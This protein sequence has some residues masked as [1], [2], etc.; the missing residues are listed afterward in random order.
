MR[1]VVLRFVAGRHHFLW[2]LRERQWLRAT[3]LGRLLHVANLL[4]VVKLEVSIVDWRRNSSIAGQCNVLIGRAHFRHPVVHFNISLAGMTKRV[5]EQKRL[6]SRAVF[7][8]LDAHRYRRNMTAV[9]QFVADVTALGPPIGIVAQQFAR[10]GDNLLRVLIEH[11]SFAVHPFAE[12]IRCRRRHIEAVDNH[13]TTR[14]WSI[15]RKHHVKHLR[16]CVIVQRSIGL[17]CNPRRNDFVG[18]DDLWHL[19]RLVGNR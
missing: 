15:E 11:E 7:G 9:R 2:L 8:C 1:A 18:S 6:I 17:Y 16:H 5:V 12:R 19:A 3:L 4:R 10:F 14:R 13:S